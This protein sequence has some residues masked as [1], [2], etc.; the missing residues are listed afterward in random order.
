[1]AR[2]DVTPE[3]FSVSC[4]TITNGDIPRSKV[5]GRN[6][7]DFKTLFPRLTGERRIN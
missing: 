1:M 5:G 7:T 4:G 6:V 3:P 2:A